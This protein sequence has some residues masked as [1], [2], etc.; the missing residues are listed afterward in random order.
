MNTRRVITSIEELIT[1]VSKSKNVRVLNIKDL[2][3]TFPFNESCL[4]RL[5]GIKEK[6]SKI[7][8]QLIFDNVEL[9]SLKLSNL[10][11]AKRFI[12]RSSTIKEMWVNNCKFYNSFSIINYGVDTIDSIEIKKSF[13]AKDACVLLSGRTTID[14]FDVEDTC[15]KRDISI[16]GLMMHKRE[17]NS[18]Y[19][20]KRTRIGRTLKIC[21]CTLFLDVNISCAV[22]KNL[23][24][25]NIND[26][27]L[28][29]ISKDIIIGQLDI[30]KSSI[31]GVLSLKN[32]AFD[33]VEISDSIVFDFNEHNFVYNNLLKDSARV[34]SSAPT[35]ISDPVKREKYLAELY[36]IKLKENIKL[37][38]QNI[39]DRIDNKNLKNYKLKL[40]IK[41][42]FWKRI[43]R[44]LKIFLLSFVTSLG[45]SE[46]LIIFLNKYSNNFNR[47]WFRGVVFT[48]VVTIIFFF[49]INYFGTK[50]PFFVMNWT[51]AGFGDVLQEYIGLLDIF[52]L[53]N[54]KS[55]LSLNTTGVL[56]LFLAR[57]FIAYGCWQTIY[58]FYKYNK[59]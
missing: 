17:A 13:F 29:R 5:L 25:K 37:S 28:K 45:S 49:L 1:I 6:N 16:S 47:S 43:L 58:A 27:V 54:R 4:Y 35:I 50:E 42:K 18:F 14:N 57:I 31:G 40:R 33:V 53:T 48:N 51:F 3:I 26:E 23:L 52:D 36:N 55:G 11:F 44:N 46:R 34:F 41:P 12:I 30:F 38:L 59:N 39:I 10:K 9:C 2:L 19:I 32:C 22:G 20:A 24:L 15:F 56:L 21:N 7:K 8:K